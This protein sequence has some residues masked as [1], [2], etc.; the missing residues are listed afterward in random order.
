M[1]FSVTKL[2]LASDRH[3]TWLAIDWESP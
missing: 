1:D 2:L 3:L